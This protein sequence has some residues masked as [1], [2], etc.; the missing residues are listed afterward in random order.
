M[1]DNIEMEDTLM[2]V[3]VTVNEAGVYTT[4]FI[5]PGATVNEFTFGT[6]EGEA[7][8][9]TAMLVDSMKQGLEYIQNVVREQYGKAEDE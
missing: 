6:D 8:A 9:K 5:V 3:K 1:K 7:K 2:S 4:S